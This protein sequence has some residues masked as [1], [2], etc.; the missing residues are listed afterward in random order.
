LTIYQTLVSILAEIG[1]EAKAAVPALLGAL[2]DENGELRGAA[3]GAIGP[4]A[5][6]AVPDLTKALQ[7]KDSDLA[8]R[9]SS[10][11]TRGKPIMRAGPVR[12][13]VDQPW[14]PAT[15]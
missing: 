12:V 13:F 11:W 8:S 6:E 3:L 1:P 14:T 9:T 2:K 7:G 10:R 4:G 15:G 5:K